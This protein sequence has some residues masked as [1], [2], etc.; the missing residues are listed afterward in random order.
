[1]KLNCTQ[2]FSTKF[3]TQIK[4]KKPKTKTFS[5]NVADIDKVLK[6]KL[7][8]KFKTIKIKFSPRAI[9]DY[10][11]IFNEHE[12]NQLPPIHGPRINHQI[13]LLGKERENSQRFCWGLF[14]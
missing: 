5:A 11:I 3:Y 1:M 10:L 7:K 2:I 6:L 8:I 13:E 4:T 9:S 12:I 14:L